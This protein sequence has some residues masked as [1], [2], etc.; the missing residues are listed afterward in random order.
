MI[1]Q[2]KAISFELDPA[3]DGGDYLSRA[4]QKEKKVAHLTRPF[5][6]EQNIVKG[7]F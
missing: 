7:C 1:S 5:S 6:V 2:F 3:L 4:V